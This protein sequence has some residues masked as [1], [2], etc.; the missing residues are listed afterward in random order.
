VTA[1]VA[2]TILRLERAALDRWGK[3]DP[4]GF[5]EI[6]AP[7]VVYFDP[8]LEQPIHGLDALTRYYDG[9]RGKISIARDEIRDATVQVAGSVAVLT[10]RFDSSGGTDDA[11]RW[12]CTEVYRRDA[13]GWRIIQTHWS[14]TNAARK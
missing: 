11:F 14:F 8:F 12:N 10:F 4:D 9:I 3:G 6:S 1:E 5:L 7:D 13:A 2:A